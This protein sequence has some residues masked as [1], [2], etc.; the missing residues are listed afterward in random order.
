[1]DA[2]RKRTWY[3]YNSC[4]DLLCLERLSAI[5]YYTGRIYKI[6][7]VDEGTATMDWMPQ[8]K[9]KGSKAWNT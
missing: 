8:E 4:C 9:Q 6:G 1:L 2:S 3:Y 5:L 7:E